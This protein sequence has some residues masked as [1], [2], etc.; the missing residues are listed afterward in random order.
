ME[1]DI[2]ILSDYNG[3]PQKSKRQADNLLREILGNE[4][5]DPQYQIRVGPELNAYCR[6]RFRGLNYPRVLQ[7]AK[8]SKIVGKEPP[9]EKTREWRYLLRG[10]S[11]GTTRKEKFELVLSFESKKVVVF[12]TAYPLKRRRCKK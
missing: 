1:K 11:S 8:S 5:V 7:I 3:L 2:I 9:T 12:I 10:W 4:K 6:K